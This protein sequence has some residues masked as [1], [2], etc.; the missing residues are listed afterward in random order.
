MRKYT[1]LVSYLGNVYH[2]DTVF[3]AR[4]GRMAE[5]HPVGGGTVIAVYVRELRRIPGPGGL[6]SSFG[7]AHFSLES[8]TVERLTFS[9]PRAIRTAYRNDVFQPLYLVS[10]SVDAMV[11]EVLATQAVDPTL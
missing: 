2:W 10:Q 11:A 7:E 3:T 4:G 9:V 1:S 6:A 5:I 8:D